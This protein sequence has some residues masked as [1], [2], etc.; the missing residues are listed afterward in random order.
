MRYNLE[1][2]L[3]ALSSNQANDR[4]VVAGREVL[5]VLRVGYNEVAEHSNL[6]VPGEHRKQFQ[7]D[8]KWGTLHQENTVATA[9]TNGTIFLYDVTTGQLER[10]LR[11]H[12]RQVHKIAFNPADGRLLLSASQDGTI[13][14]WDLR[15]R[16][17]RVTFAGRAEAARDVQFNAQNAVEFAAG[18]DNGTVQRWDYR[19]SHQCQRRISG[20]NGPVFS[21]AWHPD[22]KHLASGGRDRKVHVW[23]FYDENRQSHA[24]HTIFAIAAI[25]RIAWR[26]LR[27]GGSANLNTTELATCA[28]NNDHRVQVWDLKRVYVPTRVLDEHENSTTGILW[29]DEDTLWSCS[30]DGTFIQNDMN[31]AS[32]PINSLAHTAFAWGPGDE[33]TFASQRRGR[34]PGRVR[35]GTSLTLSSSRGTLETT[36]EDL[37]LDRRRHG[38]TSSFKGSKPSITEKS[39]LDGPLDKYVLGQSAARVTIKSLSDTEAFIFFAER[40]VFDL[41]GAS[42][43]KPYT[44]AEAFERNARLAWRAHKHR[45]AQT[46]RVLQ[47]AIASEDATLE[48][49][50]Q[51]RRTGGESMVST[52]RAS[53]LVARRALAINGPEHGH[54]SGGTTPLARPVNDSPTTPVPS[55]PTREI[56]ENLLLPPAAFGTS[57]SSSNGSTDNEGS[58]QTQRSNISDIGTEVV[59]R[60]SLT[61]I[62]SQPTTLNGEHKPGVTDPTN[63]NP[64]HSTE[65]VLPAPEPSS[66]DAEDHREMF[67][68]TSERSNPLGRDDHEHEHSTTPPPHQHYPQ[69]S[70]A[71]EHSS[72]ST[73]NQTSMSYYG[74]S[75]LSHKFSLISDQTSSSYN[76]STTDGEHDGSVSDDQQIPLDAIPEEMIMSGILKRPSAGA[77][78]PGGMG[79]P[80]LR[81]AG[82]LSPVPVTAHHY[83]SQPARATTIAPTSEDD[84][85]ARPWALQRLVD[86]L[87]EYY[88]AR[89]DVQFLTALTLLL[90][91]RC[92]FPPLRAEEWTEGY[93]SLLKRRRLFSLAAE[94]VKAAP[95]GWAVRDSAV[96]GV[97]VD[98]ACPRC[99][100]FIRGGGGGCKSCARDMAVCGVCEMRVR[101]RWTLC[102]GCEHG[103]HDDCVRAWFLGSPVERAAAGSDAAAG[104]V[105]FRE[106]C[107][108]VCLPR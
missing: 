21:V 22:G 2:P 80:E 104:G 35:S 88:S 99:G 38:R 69:H 107:D 39:I 93:I 106:G 24:K 49:L 59:R 100:H 70:T 52:Q 74:S 66:I 18:F 76:R 27:G 33:F 82:A 64:S 29:K 53:G 17:S 98:V 30:K 101:G 37:S 10:Q 50:A 60:P 96:W 97:D 103:G 42:G 55:N 77:G 57:F 72:S 91:D 20:H 79:V 92:N 61:L 47:L 19:A 26:P 94:V 25:S 67:T 6:R 102:Q 36:D 89:G 7:H 48:R 4:V 15:D 44:L 62:T 65:S 86:Q 54:R 51:Q 81:L 16:K 32:Q 58:L 12:A 11:E 43:S 1:S 90:Q 23:D 75:T 85:A 83:A 63:P 34:P 108:C 87:V 95:D 45:T 14:L 78:A 9:G 46:W 41:H 105:C 68:A 40:Y 13:K 56:S 8:V 28:I 3:L 73:S 71:A 31:F 5:R 84:L